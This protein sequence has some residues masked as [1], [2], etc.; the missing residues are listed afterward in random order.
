MR[1]PRLLCITTT[2]ACVAAC[3]RV[4]TQPDVDPRIQ[5]PLFQLEN[6]RETAP[7]TFRVG[8][9]T[10]SG[11]FVVA[12]HRDWAPLAAD[13]F[14]NLV[15]NGWYDG[16]R[17]HR[18]LDGFTAGFGIHEDPYVNVVWRARALTDD[19]VREPNTR[20]R[21]SFSKSTPH[22]RTVQVFVNLKDNSASLDVQ[23]F[24]PFAEVVEGMEVLDS[25]HSGYGDGPPRGDG[26][27]QAMAVAKGA[28]Y[29]DGF[30]ELDRILRATLVP[31]GS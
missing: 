12:V 29:L 24:A 21:L 6:F 26:V 1:L 3:E 27:Y 23:G 2:L 19:P 30:P 5:G 31:P 18:V 16:V 28:E 9:E 7:G 20:G 13:R 25:L 22:S 4:E 15:K 10:S 17:F 8:F 11:D 14:F